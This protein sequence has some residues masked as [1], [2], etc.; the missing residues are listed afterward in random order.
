MRWGRKDTGMIRFD[1][2]R[3]QMFFSTGE[4]GG[5]EPDAKGPEP[6]E[7]TFDE[8]ISANP[9]YQAALDK[10][11]AKA[12]DTNRAKVEASFREQLD[13]A[14]KEAEKL[15]KMNAD[16]KKQYEM[17]QLQAKYEEV[18]A[19][20]ARVELGKTATEMLKEHE[21]EATQAMLDFVVGTDAESTKENI[22][23]FG[24]I[25]HAQVKAAE[26]RRATGSTPK[27]YSNNEDAK[28]EIQKRID[29]IRRRN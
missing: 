27:S 18:S 1:K 16:Q 24:E 29:A 5:A 7:P 9:D 11:I 12:L 25:I 13:A 17:D 28:S 20:L 26:L 8:L 22:D 3:N 21:I 14:K 23:K 6:K 10:K 4:G 15:A 2:I 19:Q